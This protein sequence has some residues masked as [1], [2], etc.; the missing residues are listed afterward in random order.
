ME[1]YIT[2]QELSN[3][4]KYSTRS[5]YNMIHN[6]VFIEGKH[7]VKPS[8]KKI[9]FFWTEMEKWLLKTQS[10]DATIGSESSA[11]AISEPTPSDTKTPRLVKSAINI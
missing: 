6:K 2:L 3:R 11:P 8:R 5:L 4:I 9:L 7:Y 1:E 10:P